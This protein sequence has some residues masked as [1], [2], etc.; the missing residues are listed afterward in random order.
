MKRIQI[1][2]HDAGGGHRNAAVALR[3]VIEEQKRPWDVELVQLQELLDPLDLL[4][5][6]TGYRIQ[7]CY[8]TLLRNGWTFGSTGLLRV[9]QATIRTYHG[10]TVKLLGAYWRQHPADLLVSVVPHFNRALC[11][12]WRGVHGEKPFVT[13][14]TDLADFPPHFWIERQIQHFVC[15]TARAAEQ[16]R[17]FGHDAAHV[18]RASGM[19]L[20][21]EFYT[22]GDSDPAA[23]RRELGLEPGLPTGIVLFGGHGSKVMSDIAERLDAAGLPIQLILICGKNESLAAK[24]RARQWRMPVHIIGFTAEVHR[25]MRAADFFIGKPGPGSISEAVARGLSIIIEC[26]AWTLPQERYNA[27]WVKEKSAGLILKSFREIAGAVVELLRDG[28]LA[29]YRAN[30]QAI[31]NRAVFEIPEFFATLL[32]GEGRDVLAF[33]A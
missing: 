27:E 5:R 7:E 14:L 25:I 3:R 12:S 13:I 24:L 15:G 31:Q 30:A 16:A 8:N 18:F 19:I 28:V 11:E 6:L 26:N 22:L 33:R 20:R 10:P 17:A 2:F 4:R 23:L 29:G 21:P 1:V 32:G 9:L